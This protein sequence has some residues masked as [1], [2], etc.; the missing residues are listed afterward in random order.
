MD[1][2]SPYSRRPTP[3]PMGGVRRAADLV[4]A[5]RELERSGCIPEAIEHFESAIKAAEKAGENAVLA[6]AL[7]RL[8][9]AKHERG[10][11]AIARALCERSHEAA[12][13]ANNAILAG[14]ALNTLGAM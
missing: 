4:I 8:G 5:A 10:E 12:L 3:P 7:R 13:Q 6:E 11:R 2:G 14:E 1:A 9:R